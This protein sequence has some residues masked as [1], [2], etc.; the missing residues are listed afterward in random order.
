MTSPHQ[1]SCVLIL[2]LTALGACGA[3][4]IPAAPTQAQSTQALGPI[5]PLVP[6]CF[7]SG[8]ATQGLSSYTVLNLVNS[9]P[10]ASCLGPNQ[11]ETDP[12]Q[13]LYR[14]TTAGA[15]AQLAAAQAALNAGQPVYL[16]MEV[17]GLAT[18]LGGGAGCFQ[19]RVNLRDQGG[20]VCWLA[21]S[22]C[23]SAPNGDNSVTDTT[24]YRLPLGTDL[25]T[26]E[27]DLSGT[28]SASCLVNLSQAHGDINF[29]TA[30]KVYF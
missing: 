19:A 2:T 22:G 13:Q 29:L 8:A 18:Q 15:A 1:L 24:V 3:P 30:P 23:V 28:A 5:P 12:G 26:L 4:E 11:Q 7:D 6:P 17:D 25:A 16:R 14:G 20:A 27:V 9:P 21:Y 10:W